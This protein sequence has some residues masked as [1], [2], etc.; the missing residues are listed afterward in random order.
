LSYD[1][2]V[3]AGDRFARSLAPSKGAVLL[4]R[5]PGNGGAGGSCNLTLP[6]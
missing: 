3:A 5:R 2:K 4:I 6:D 1:P